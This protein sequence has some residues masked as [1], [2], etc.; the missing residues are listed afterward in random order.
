MQKILFLS[1]LLFF[2]TACS[3]DEQVGED[4]ETVATQSQPTVSGKSSGVRQGLAAHKLVFFLDPNGG[5]CRLQVTI[6]NDM[7]AELRGKIDIQ[8]VQTTVPGDRDIFYQYGIRALPTL[9]LADANGK[10]I[11][12]MSPGVKQSDD[13][14]RLIKTIPHS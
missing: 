2:I 5:P 7:A 4:A 1:F 11:S 14:R 8:Y 10:E 6:L 13:I 9:L 12:R 3:N